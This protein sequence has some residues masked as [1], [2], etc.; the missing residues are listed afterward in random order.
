MALAIK[1]KD[2]VQCR[3]RSQGGFIHYDTREVVR[4]ESGGVVVAGG[5]H[6]EGRMVARRD[7]LTVIPSE[8]NCDGCFC[9]PCDCYP[10][11]EGLDF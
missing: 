2:F 7:V 8:S 1:E 3:F 11:A 4:V 9:R 5:E 10:D 6:D